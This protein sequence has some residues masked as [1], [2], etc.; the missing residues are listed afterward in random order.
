VVLPA[1]LAY[2]AKS[3]FRSEV[4]VTFGVPIP[5]ADLPWGAGEDPAAVDALTERLREALESLTVN[6]ERW[7]DLNVVQGVRSMALDLAG[8]KA[9]PEDEGEITRR[10]VA[11]FY[12]ARMEH[13]TQLHA[14]LVKARA[15]LRMLDLLGLKDED[16]VREATAGSALDKVWR[17]L[18]VIVLGYPPA[19][20]GWIFNFLP[21]FITGRMAVLAGAGRDVVAT[22]KIYGGL[23]FFPLFY[24]LQGWL[25]WWAAGP[26]WAVPAV[27][28]GAPCGLW[29]IRYY[30][31]RAKFVRLAAAALSLRSNKGTVVRLLELRGEVV[32]V[33]KP[34]VD[35]YK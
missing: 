27:L 10:L 17:R 18:A 33:L 25:L 4:T 29:A 35:M 1:G 9:T 24:L 34:L 16:V 22:Y 28:L 12:R 2:S 31:I 11:Q 14:L 30:A 8:V 32:E 7:E 23:L 6:A 3:A 5:Y 20:Y 21:Y 19:A 26:L 15:Y 13:P